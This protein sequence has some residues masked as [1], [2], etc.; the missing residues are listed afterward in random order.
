MALA[1]QSVEAS[2]LGREGIE[3][4]QIKGR[5]EARSHL[6]PSSGIFPDTSHV[7]CV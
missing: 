6:V 5:G 2:G 1:A 3:S 7:R 4:P